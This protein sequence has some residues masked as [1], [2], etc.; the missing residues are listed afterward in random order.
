M[1]EEC[2]DARTLYEVTV[3]LSLFAGISEKPLSLKGS[4]PGA[5]IVEALQTMLAPEMAKRNLVKLT[6]KSGECL[7]LI[8]WSLEG[9]Y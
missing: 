5:P 8:I 1:L 9:T 3:R 4:W 7:A 2:R 6:K